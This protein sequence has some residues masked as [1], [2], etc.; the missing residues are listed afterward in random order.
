MIGSYPAMIRAAQRAREI[1]RMY[2]TPLVLWQ[3]GKV[4]EIPPDEIEDLPAELLKLARFKGHVRKK[5][6]KS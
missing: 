1:A 5:R 4:V 2:R 3:D 6:G